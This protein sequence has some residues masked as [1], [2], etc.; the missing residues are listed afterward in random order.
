VERAERN[1]QLTDTSSTNNNELVF[2]HSERFG[3]FG[4]WLVVQVL[5]FVKRAAKDHLVGIFGA[6]VRKKKFPEE[7]GLKEFQGLDWGAQSM[8]L[9]SK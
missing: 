8:N 2:G 1:A 6:F 7:R 4:L 3:W 5:L 9:P